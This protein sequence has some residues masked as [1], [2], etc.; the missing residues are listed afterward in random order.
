MTS[1][2]KHNCIDS[3]QL[4]ENAKNNIEKYGL[5]VIIIEATDY[6]PSF[7]YSI[8]F[9]QKYRHP[10]IICFGLSNSLLQTLIN[11]VA[12]IIKENESIIEGKNYPDIFENA[13]A[14]FLKVHPDNI[15]DYFGSAIN[16]YEKEDFPAFQLVWT[17]RN[18]KFPW[19]E[20]FEEEFRHKQPLLDRNNNFKFIEP[21]NLAT[22][23][24]KQWLEGKSVVRVVHDHDG[25]WLFFTDDEVSIEDSVIV[26]LEQLITKD[27]TLNQV[28]DLEYGEEAER[29]F[30]GDKWIRNKFEPDDE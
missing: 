15:S 2:K 9:W 23:T 8:G 5:Q 1:E 29:R 7:A 3:D 6:L 17:D 22:F 24:T 14:E 10:E 12:E 13:R 19:E 28:F 30:I 20:N 16:F 18:D 4:I 25:D 27:N 21:K 26:A 11:N